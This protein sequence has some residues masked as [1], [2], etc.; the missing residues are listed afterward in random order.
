MRNRRTA[1][2]KR[3]LLKELESRREEKK[4]VELFLK[5]LLME[6]WWS[7]WSRKETTTLPISPG[8]EIRLTVTPDLSPGKRKA[9]GLIKAKGQIINWSLVAEIKPALA[10]LQEQRAALRSEQEEKMFTTGEEEYEHLLIDLKALGLCRLQ[11]NRDNPAEY[12]FI[13][14]RIVPFGMIRIAYQTIRFRL[15]QNRIWI[16]RFRFKP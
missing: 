12:G 13:R 5:G 14:K 8:L 16:L 1:R 10:A 11:T 6:R 15:I 9:E 3:E 2:Q 7:W 4:A